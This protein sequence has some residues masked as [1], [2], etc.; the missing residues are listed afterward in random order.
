VVRVAFVRPRVM[1]RVHPCV[2]RVCPVSFYRNSLLRLGIG[3]LFLFIN[4]IIN[5]R[6]LTFLNQNPAINV[7]IGEG[8]HLFCFDFFVCDLY[9]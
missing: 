5:P 6:N 9:M 1:P 2:S 7:N 3:N 8:D 4:L